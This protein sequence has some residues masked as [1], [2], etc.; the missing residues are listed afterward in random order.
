MANHLVIEDADLL[1]DHLEHHFKRF[2]L[3]ELSFTD[4]TEQAKRRGATVFLVEK[5]QYNGDNERVSPSLGR[6][7]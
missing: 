5:D 1:P 6:C 7:G 2:V 3:D 4:L